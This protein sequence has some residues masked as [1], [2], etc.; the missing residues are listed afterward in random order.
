MI[1]DRHC[2]V[3]C[4][5]VLPMRQIASRIADAGGLE[6]RTKRCQNGGEGKKNLLDLESGGRTEGAGAHSQPA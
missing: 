3:R 4:C 1:A 2:T 5:P 6:G